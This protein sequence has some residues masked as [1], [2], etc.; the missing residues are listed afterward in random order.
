[1]IPPR[2]K[3]KSKVF[4]RA[5]MVIVTI[6]FGGI[7]F[8]GS[9]SN[10]FKADT[11]NYKGVEEVEFHQALPGRLLFYQVCSFCVPAALTISP[12][13]DLLDLKSVKPTTSFAAFRPH[14]AFSLAITINAP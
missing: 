14:H 9:K 12:I 11:D 2:I 6:V 8:C 4:L 1:M 3:Y 7:I 5:T 10:S 13:L